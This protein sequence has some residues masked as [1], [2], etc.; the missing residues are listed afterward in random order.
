MS[1][2]FAVNQVS[3]WRPA[4]EMLAPFASKA[5]RHKRLRIPLKE[6]S[7]DYLGKMMTKNLGPKI[8][9]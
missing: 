3:C 1:F 9:F 8:F 6:P 5:S 7:I 4:S 2:N